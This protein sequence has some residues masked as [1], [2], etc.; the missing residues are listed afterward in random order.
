VIPTGAA[1][2][3]LSRSLLRTSRAA[4]WSDILTEAAASIHIQGISLRLIAQATSIWFF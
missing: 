2:P 3:F 1:R 4:Q